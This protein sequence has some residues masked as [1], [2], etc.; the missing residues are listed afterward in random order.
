SPRDFESRASASSAIPAGAR[1]RTSEVSGDLPVLALLAGAARPI[2]RRDG[3]GA[4]FGRL[5]EGGSRMRTSRSVALG[6]AL[7]VVVTLG[8][9]CSKD[10]T[11]ANPGTSGTT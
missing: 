10:T 6:A 1:Q 5:S 4:P 9:A 8:V 3:T 2:V 11:S 7:A